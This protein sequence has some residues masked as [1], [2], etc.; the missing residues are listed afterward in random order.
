MKCRNCKNYTVVN[1]TVDGFY[2]DGFC[3][4]T[5]SQRQQCRRCEW[6]TQ[7]TETCKG[8]C[9]LFEYNTDELGF[10][11]LGC[12]SFKCIGDVKSVFEE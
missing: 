7:D 9:T 12:E 5:I 8:F 3:T 6:Y 4:L 2:I 10:D 1:K 11:A